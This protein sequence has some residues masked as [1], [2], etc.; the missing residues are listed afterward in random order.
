MDKAEEA[1][2]ELRR[3]Y[4]EEAETALN[5]E[6]IIANARALSGDVALAEA[7]LRKMMEDHADSS[8]GLWAGSRLANLLAGEGR[9]DEALAL[10]DGL[11]A[12]HR[13]DAGARTQLRLERAQLLVQMKE[14]DKAVESLTAVASEADDVGQR[15]SAFDLLAQTYMALRRF[16]DARAG[17]TAS[18]R[19]TPAT[20]RPWLRRK[21]AWDR[22]KGSGGNTRR[23]WRYSKKR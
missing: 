16:D 9:F 8:Q 20:R 5:A 12:K 14:Y 10:Y 22:S 23:R 21:S 7:R 11:I 2:D 6:V 17:T 19:N 4:P 3:R 15:R 13:R 18:K 1:L